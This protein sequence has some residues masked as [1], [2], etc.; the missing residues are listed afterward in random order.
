VMAFSAGGY[1]AWL[2]AFLVRE[3]G[4]TKEDAT[5]L[6]ALALCGG[7]TGILVGGRISDRLRARHPAGRLWTIVIGMTLTMPCAAIA[8][9][10]APGI[11][12]QIAGVATL[13]FIS[14]YH[15]PMAATVDD[16]APPGLTVA[17]QGLV[18]FTMHM[19]GTAPSSWLIG[20]I[21]EYW[22]LHIAMWVPTV[23]LV[24]A[25]LCMAVATSSFA[26]DQARA[27]GDH[28]VPSL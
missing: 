18:I 11:G 28:G 22:D 9:E 15:A 26:A 5:M 27:R 24:I 1:N 25:A 23:G 14:W 8:I 3:R 17:A 4:M 20:E 7:L 19:I 2:Q 16:L 6:L 21:S 12:L 10:I 13:F